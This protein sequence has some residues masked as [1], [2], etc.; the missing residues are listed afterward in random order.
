MKMR[1]MKLASAVFVVA[2]II[3][4]MGMLAG[5]GGSKAQ[6]TDAVSLAEANQAAQQA[7]KNYHMDMDMDMEATIKMDGLKDVMG[8]DSLT[9]PMS[10][11]MSMDSGK[12]T[13]HATSN[14]K[15]TMLGQ[16]IDQNA[17]Q[18]IDIKN[19]VTYTKAEGTNQW[20]KTESDASMS[21]MMDS[22]SKMSKDMLSKAEF[23]ETED[24]YTLTLDA[25][26]MGDMIKELGLFDS[27]SSADMELEEFSIDSGQ[28][29]YTFDKESAL[30]TKSE[31]KELDVKAKGTEQGISAD[32]QIP[33]SATME[34]SH[35][36][37]LD[38]KDYEIPSDVTGSN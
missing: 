13:A 6:I 5:C 11:T 33:V 20:T 7:A 24:S 22:M 18:Y 16:S 30:L 3:G 17:E 21:D 37:E 10:I 34:Y 38:P 12:E 32:M 27:I 35:Y 36:G 14:T 4:T 26:V 28:I 23:A 2:I 15:M 25:E 8:T 31:I 9:M 29:V 19:G 1:N